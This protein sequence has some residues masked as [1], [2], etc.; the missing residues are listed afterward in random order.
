[1]EQN[2]AFYPRFRARKTDRPVPWTETKPD[3]K[4]R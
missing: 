3:A 2:G 4:N 1:M